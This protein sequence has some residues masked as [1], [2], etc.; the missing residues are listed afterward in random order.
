MKGYRFVPINGDEEVDGTIDCC[1]V[2]IVSH[3]YVVAM[4]L[5]RSYSSDQGAPYDGVSTLSIMF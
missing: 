1:L 5:H 3:R 2:T 4:D